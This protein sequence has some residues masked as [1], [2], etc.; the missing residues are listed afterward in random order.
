MKRDESAIGS[1]A[2]LIMD[3]AGRVILWAL[4]VFC[5]YA[6][7]RW[8]FRMG[9]EVFYQEP[10]E[11]APGTDFS[12]RVR[13]GDR[14]RDVALELEDRGIIQ[15]AAAFEIQ[16]RLY[17]TG[18]YPGTYGLNTSMTTKEL[19]KTLNTTETEYLERLREEQQL[20]GNAASEVGGGSDLVDE[21]QARA[22]VR[23]GAEVRSGE[24][25][26]E[27]EKTD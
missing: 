9:H 19:L 6:G 22:A 4:M 10:S 24:S 13:E 18:I 11:A 17:K 1:A 3:V 27:V 25:L 15:N 7:A 20:R 2:D 14:L 23:A 16:G 12:F 26:V 8:C 5:L 21:S